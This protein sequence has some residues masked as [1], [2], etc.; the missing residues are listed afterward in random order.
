VKAPRQGQKRLVIVGA[1]G[2]VGGYA[3][4]YALANPDVAAVTSIGRRTLGIIHPRLGEV[5][6]QDFS[7]CDT[8]EE[9]LSGLDGAIFCLGTYTEPCRTRSSTR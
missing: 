2:M 7:D 8:L 9:A 1:T 6:H 3:L 5:V 4:R